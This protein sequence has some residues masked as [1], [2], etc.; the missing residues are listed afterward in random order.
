[1]ATEEETR[2]LRHVGSTSDLPPEARD[3]TKPGA[4]QARTKPMKLTEAV[5]NA[6][7]LCQPCFNRGLLAVQ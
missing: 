7:Y 2:T 6:P 3:V 4:V 1:M 5:G